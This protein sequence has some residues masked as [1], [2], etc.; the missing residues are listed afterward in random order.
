MTI[1]ERLGR[2]PAVHALIEGLYVRAEADPL[3][4]P[5]LEKIDKERLKAHQF[6]F[7]S[8][9][10]GGPHVYTGRSLAL[11]HAGLRI[12]AHHFDAFVGHLE[13]TLGEI[14]TPDDITAE[15]LSRVKALRVVIVSEPSER[16]AA[17]A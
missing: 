15:I 17:S 9:A 11:A 1:Y 3:L 6:A 12:E 10:V 5:F 4:A 7:I 2:E 8:Q 14:G 13:S 16:A